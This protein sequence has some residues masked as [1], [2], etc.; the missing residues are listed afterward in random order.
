M[1]TDLDDIVAEDGFKL[2]EELEDCENREE[3]CRAKTRTKEGLKRLA[4]AYI[5]GAL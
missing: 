2:A 3:Q 5:P 1:I 4:E